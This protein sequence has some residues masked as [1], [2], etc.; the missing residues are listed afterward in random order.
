MAKK[1]QA[2]TDPYFLAL[3]SI[4]SQARLRRYLAEA[5]EDRDA[6]A[7]YA[8]NTA[9]CEALYPAL[10]FVEVAVRNH[11]NIALAKHFHI[12]APGTYV[13]I[14]SWLDATPSVLHEKETRWVEEAKRQLRIDNGKRPHDQRRMTPGRLVAALSF[15]F[16]TSL[17][18]SRYDE[19]GSAPQELWP[20]LARD[21]FPGVPRR[22]RTRAHLSGYVEDIRELRNRAFHHEPIWEP[23]QNGVSLY[24]RHDNMIQF[25]SWIDS[26]LSG[27]LSSLDR[28]R[29]VYDRGPEF[30]RPIVDEAASKFA[31]P[32]AAGAE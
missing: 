28:F 14:Q 11:L 22:L 18:N 32:V 20:M 26:G 7:L 3:Q 15:G 30:F 4:L 1:K 9:L 5:G 6:L 16:W 21:H 31:P 10:H 12:H 23:N 25:L 8:W 24:N 2:P 27:L 29:E 19:N 17:F 13:E